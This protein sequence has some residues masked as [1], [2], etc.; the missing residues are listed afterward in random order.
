MD[1]N[2]EHTNQDQ[3]PQDPFRRPDLPAQTAGMPENT[4]PEKHPDADEA[5]QEARDA[6][7]AQ[8]AALTVGHSGTGMS[9]LDDDLSVFF[10]QPATTEQARQNGQPDAA[11][12]VPVRNKVFISF[13]R[14][15][16]KYLKILHAHLRY[17]ERAGTIKFWDGTRIEPGSKWRKAIEEALATASIAVLLVSAD[18]LASDFIADEELPYLLAAE[19]RG[20]RI[21]SVILRPCAFHYT[22]LAQFEA[23]NPPSHPLST[24][25][26]AQQETV[27]VKL[28]DVIR[29]NM[30]PEQSSATQ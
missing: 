13:N 4:E 11:T 8:P 23:I 27:W 18:F 20:M 24:M 26:E 30:H 17:D 10:A 28:T 7:P 12:P 5:L 9:G 16:G 15:D 1:I 3:L 19:A 25:S 22:V 29:R 2:Y 14:K 6:L 21:Y